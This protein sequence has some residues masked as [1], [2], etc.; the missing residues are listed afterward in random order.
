MFV[1]VSCGC[2]FRSSGRMYVIMNFLDFQFNILT[3]C[4]IFPLNGTSQWKS[5]GCSIYRVLVFGLLALIVLLMTIQLC[6]APDLSVLARTIDMW[7]MFLSGLYKWIYMT[8]FNGQF[9][10]LNTKLAEIQDQ[11]SIVYG[12]TANQFTK[13]YFKNTTRIIWWYLFFGMIM[14]FLI[15][16]NPFLTYS[17]K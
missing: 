1:K 10:N 9:A 17:Q 12:N 11:G 14:V 6:V 7:T 4:G 16:V 13:N 2:P 3:C 5:W 15:A 8:M